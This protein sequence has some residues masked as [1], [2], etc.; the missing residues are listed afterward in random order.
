M[1]KPR[2]IWWGYVKQVIRA[3]PI[4]RRELA[5][6]PDETD[7]TRRMRLRLAAVDAA[8]S[9]TQRQRDGESRIAII[10][11]VYFRRSHTLEGAAAAC[12]VCY[13]TAR[14]WNGDFVRL[15]ARHLGVV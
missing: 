7:T 8:I 1:S 4:Y 3:A 14:R 10:D 5:R 11:K 15:V 2:E 6:H 12:F 9:E 13:K